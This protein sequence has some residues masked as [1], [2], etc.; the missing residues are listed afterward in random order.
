MTKLFRL[1][2][3]RINLRLQQS[4]TEVREAVVDEVNEATAE[5]GEA[6]APTG[7]LPVEANKVKEAPDTHQ[8]LQINVVTDIIDTEPELFIVFSL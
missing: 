4:P 7:A 2:T 1:S 8:I 3:V 6:E 5:T